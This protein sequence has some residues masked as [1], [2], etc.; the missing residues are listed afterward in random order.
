M[1]LTLEHYGR[2]FAV[3]IDKDDCD[4]DEMR[5][6]LRGLLVAGGWQPSSAETIVGGEK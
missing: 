4:A 5:D 1:R 6:L 3:Q 2:A